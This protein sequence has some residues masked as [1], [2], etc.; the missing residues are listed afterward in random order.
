MRAI[1]QTDSNPDPFAGEPFLVQ[2]EWLVD[3]LGAPDLVVLDVGW[4]VPET[5]KSGAV[6]F[7]KGHILGARHLD[8]DAISDLQSPHVN[9]LPSPAHFAQAVA[10]LGVGQGSRVVLYDGS[11]VSARVWWMFRLFGHHKVAI[12]DG[13]LRRWQAEARPMASGAAAPPDQPGD[14]PARPPAP[15]QLADW[16]AVLAALQAAPGSPDHRQ[17][18]DARTPARFTGE[19]AS[20]YPGVA[21]GHMPGAINLSWL[22]LIDQ[23]PPY[24]FLPPEAARARFLAAGVD[25]GRPVIATC[26]SGVTACIIAFQ[27]Q[28]LGLRDW[29]I[30][31]GSWHEW[32]QRPDLPKESVN[33]EAKP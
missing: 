12:L 6:E 26:G 21:G 24:R 29:Q 28:R 20:G 4:F 11:Y 23:Q 27:L 25:L 32:G 30:Y 7:T 1:L 14:F 15:G 13:G 2:P 3:H 10:A 18:L 31:D 8:L 17:I 19:M 22:D 5:G 9:M 16:R 33:P